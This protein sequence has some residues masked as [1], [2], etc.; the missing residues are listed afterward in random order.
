MRAASSVSSPRLGKVAGVQL[1]DQV[2]RPALGVGRTCPRAAAG[3]GSGCRRPTHDGALMARRQE[4]GAIGGRAALDPAGR[5]GQDDE[6]GQVL[7]LGPQAVADPAPQARPAHQDRA[8]VHLVDG[9]GMVDA[10]GP[11]RADHR[12]VV[13]AVGDVGQEVGDLEAALA[14]A[15]EGPLGGQQRVVPPPAAGW[16]P[17]RSS[18]GSGWPARRWRSGLGSNVSR[19]LGPP[20]MNR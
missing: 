20:C 3:R 5:V 8:G 15:A 12:Q 14:V 1:A 2:E 11:A 9:L 17:G 6:R 10:V 19:W 13:G 16:P 7:V 4:A 18:A